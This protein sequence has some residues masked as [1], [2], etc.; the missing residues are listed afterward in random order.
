[1]SKFSLLIWWRNTCI[2]VVVNFV[3]LI[4]FLKRQNNSVLWT[5]YKLCM[6][7]ISLFTG[8]LPSFFFDLL[9]SRYLADPLALTSP[10]IKLR[11]RSASKSIKSVRS[12]V[13]WVTSNRVSDDSLGSESLNFLIVLVDHRFVLGS[14]RSVVP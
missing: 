1:M 10:P 9:L 2:W 11:P 3:C 4:Y 6:K 13:D 14:I 7:L 12:N 5:K 8:F